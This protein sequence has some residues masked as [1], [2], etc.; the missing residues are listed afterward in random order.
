MKALMLVLLALAVTSLSLPAAAARSATSEPPIPSDYESRSAI[1]SNPAHAAILEKADAAF[2]EGRWAQAASLFGSLPTEDEE[3]AHYPMRRRCQ[4][5]TE[6]GLRAEAVDACNSLLRRVVPDAADLQAAVAALM[7]GSGRPSDADL[8][9]ATL[10]MQRVEGLDPGSVWSEAARCNVAERISDRAALAGC[11]AQLAQL[12]PGSRLARPFTEVAEGAQRR[13]FLKL[14]L[15]GAFALA[16]LGTLLHRVFSGRRA[17]A[18]ISAAFA[19]LCFQVPAHAQA[20]APGAAA[21]DAA[22]VPP[23]SGSMSEDPQDVASA[24]NR[25]M[26]LVQ[27]LAEHVS[28]AEELVKKND[29]AGAVNEFVE[30]VTQ[31]PYFVKGWRRLCEGY[32]YLGVPVEGAHACRQVLESPDSNA[33]DRA[34]LVHHLLSGPEGKKT[35]VRAEAKQLA[36]AA[37]ALA[38]G[39]RWG[40]DAQCE[41]ALLVD[42][43]VTLKSC[44]EHLDRLAPDDRKTVAL[45]FSVALREKRLSDAEAIIERASAGGMDAASVE[46]MRQMVAAQR[47]LLARVWRAAPLGVGLGAMAGIIALLGRFFWGM[48]SRAQ[49]LSLTESRAAK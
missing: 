15:L 37:V 23:A 39:E 7:L 8:K 24:I 42:D 28:Q 2:A 10:L 25:D 14:G 20:A 12:A 35:E 46:R 13:R 43:F 45:A 44:S 48:R 27:K 33:W 18:M 21:P 22:P 1:G 9:Q 26:E 36:D 40:Y 3:A 19:L 29:W 5:L 47:P 17:A 6:Q 31:A 49:R 38:P 11:S 32:A 41:L 4:A 30:V 16:L 34:M